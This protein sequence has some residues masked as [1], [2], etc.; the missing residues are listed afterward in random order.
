LQQRVTCATHQ[1]ISAGLCLPACL[2][3]GAIE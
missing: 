3:A 2:P 1:H